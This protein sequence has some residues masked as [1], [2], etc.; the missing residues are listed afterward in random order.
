MS[1]EPDPTNPELTVEEL[2]I[3]E[4]AFPLDGLL[5]PDFIRAEGL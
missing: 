1:G 5:P 4:A 3:L 2:V